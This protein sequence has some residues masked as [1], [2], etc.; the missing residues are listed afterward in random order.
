[1]KEKRG[2]NEGGFRLACFPPS[3][4]PIRNR[5]SLRA[6]HLPTTS[7]GVS[8]PPEG[9]VGETI[10]QISFLYSSVA[11]CSPSRVFFLFEGEVTTESISSLRQS[12]TISSADRR[13]CQPPFSIPLENFIV[14]CEIGKD[15]GGWRME[16]FVYDKRSG[17]LKIM[18][19]RRGFI[20]AGW[21]FYFLSEKVFSWHPPPPI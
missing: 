18:E 12:W 9:T 2:D 17:N 11:N 10:S 4:Y 20:F 13:N 19:G 5:G 8:P 3:C 21:I 14:G 16:L 7:Q 15:V 6:F 1:M